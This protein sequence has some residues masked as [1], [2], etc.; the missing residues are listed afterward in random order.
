VHTQVLLTSPAIRAQEAFNGA[1]VI[2]A[3][4]PQQ[5]LLTTSALWM[6]PQPAQVKEGNPC[7]QGGRTPSRCSGNRKGFGAGRN[8]TVTDLVI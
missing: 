1:A 4:L 6:K 5:Q 7:D 3:E 8:A 2:T